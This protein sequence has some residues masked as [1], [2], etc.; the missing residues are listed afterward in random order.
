MFEFFPQAM[1]PAVDHEGKIMM[2]SPLEIK[3]APNGNGGF[4]DSIVKIDRVREHIETLD[5]V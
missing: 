2:H 4:F 5:Y 1:L 3:L